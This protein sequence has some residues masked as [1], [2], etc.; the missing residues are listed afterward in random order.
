MT[1]G[2]KL[3][4]VFVVLMLFMAAW[5]SSYDIIVHIGHSEHTVAIDSIDY[6]SFNEPN[7]MCVH[8]RDSSAVEFNAVDSITIREVFPD[9]L[10]IIYEGHY[11][12]VKN[13]HADAARVC[14]ND[15]NAD[16]LLTITEKYKAP[17]VSVSGKSTDGRLRIDSEVDYTLV[18]NGLNLASTHASAIN[19]MSKQKATVILADGT[20]NVLTD[21][22]NCVIEDF[23][24][25]SNGCFA[26]Q[27]ALTIKGEGHLSVTGNMK[28]AV[29]AKKSITIK[30]GTLAVPLAASDAIHSGKNVSIEG[31]ELHL[32]GMKGDGID[33]DDDFTMT[34]GSLEMLIEGEAAK[35]V[36]CGKLMVIE[37][38]SI[39]AKASGA[40]KNKK[41]DLAYCTI[42]KCD[43]SMTVTDGDFNLVNSSPGGKCISVAHNLEISGGTFYMET[44]GDGAGYT[45]IEGETDYYTSKCL[46]A[47]D[48]LCILQGSLQCLSTG[49]GGKGIVGGN[50]TQIGLE[51]DTAY[52]QG[53]TIAVET[54]N[55]SIVDDVEEDERY[56]CPKAIKASEYLYVFSGDIH[57]TTHGMGG[58]GVECG[59]EMYFYGGSLECNCFDDGI[60]IGEKL[61]VL[62]GQIY[63][64]S[65]DNDGID[66]NG[67]IYLKGGVIVATNQSWPNESFDAEGG[68]VYLEGASVFGIGKSGVKIAK[69]N[70]PYYNT[71]R[72]N[73]L[74][75]QITTDF[76]FNKDRYIYIIHADEIIFAIK[77]EKNMENVFL[78]IVDP[79][80]MEEERYSIFEG[81]CPL[82]PH[83]ALFKNK[84]IIGGLPNNI[85]LVRNFNPTINTK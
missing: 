36:K 9:T 4:M 70:Y 44:S 76:S 24:E 67:S 59:K 75:E 52:Q 6:I 68:C 17:I 2:R 7:A 35:G 45:N 20:D 84:V 39:T 54:T 82:P 16:V 51:T 30:D 53:P 74:Y 22:D 71:D 15:S 23:T 12:S 11:T 63:C 33:L 41:G 60:N 65:E 43:S 47:D 34:G 49:V 57:A 77:V 40:L 18:L 29:Y 48:T 8:L 64:N 3:L 32:L 27:G 79:S 81:D 72:Q 42:L 46:A 50:Y 85:D 62:G 83:N 80:F 58:E 14:L 69:S 13:P 38:G 19:S 5:A 61:E 55:S 26:F 28:H 66:S 78:T 10:Y 56:G 37:G 1:K 21:A 31:G 25:T 73:S